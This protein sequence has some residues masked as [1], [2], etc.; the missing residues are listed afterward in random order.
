M[1]GE[2]AAEVPAGVRGPLLGVFDEAAWPPNHIELPDEWTLIVF[3]DGIIEGR[4]VE[5]SDEGERLG[6]R[7]SHGWPPSS[8]RMPRISPRLAD[9]LIAAAEQANGEPL[10]DDVAL[11][12]LSASTRWTR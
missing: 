1:V 6:P 12:I 10:H 7:A 2:D 9:D 4:A 8:R 5:G 3:T 11:V